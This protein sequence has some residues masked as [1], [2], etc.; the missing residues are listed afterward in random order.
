MGKRVK[1]FHIPSNVEDTGGV[2]F[3]IETTAFTPAAYH[4]QRVATICTSIKCAANTKISS[5]HFRWASPKMLHSYGLT[6][7][8]LISAI[9]NF[10]KF[11]E[12]LH[13]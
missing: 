9:S 1:G 7:M 2:T 12:N 4:C 3:S 5:L 13:N 10:D 11:I 8:K 6:G